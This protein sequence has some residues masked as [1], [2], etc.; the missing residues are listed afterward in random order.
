MEIELVLANNESGNIIKN[1]YPLYLYDLSEIYGNIPNEYGIYEDEPIKTLEEQYHV[2]DI[3]FQKPEL[4]FPFI[5]F[6]DKKPAG[7][8]LVSTGE[9]SPKDID[10]YLYEFFFT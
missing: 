8:A 2:Q 5:I 6:A 4:L 9:Y 1:L 7:F 3:W 10:Y